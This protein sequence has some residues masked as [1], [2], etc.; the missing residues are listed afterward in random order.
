LPPIV[1]DRRTG[2]LR[3]TE[4]GCLTGFGALSADTSAQASGEVG[5]RSV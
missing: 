3:R 4:T 1:R 5:S 2:V